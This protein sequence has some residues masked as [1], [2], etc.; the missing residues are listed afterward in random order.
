MQLYMKIL[1]HA[2]RARC[3][4][5]IET[6]LTAGL[7]AGLG[8]DSMESICAYLSSNIN[9]PNGWRSPRCD[10]RWNFSAPNPIIARVVIICPLCASR[11]PS[12]V[13]Q[14]DAAWHSAARSLWLDGVGVVRG[15]VG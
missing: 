8:L 15:G 10:E 3:L 13:D 12:D 1:V 9:S 4:A 6:G 11:L 14:F 5:V 7:T 2:D